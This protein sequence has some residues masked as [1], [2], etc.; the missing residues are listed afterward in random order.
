[1]QV[2]ILGAPEAAP[3][4]RRAANDG[5]RMVP[6]VGYRSSTDRF[7]RGS[8]ARQTA[9]RGRERQSALAAEP[10]LR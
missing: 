4:P 7:E 5:N 10:R 3:A 1:M 6:T 9:S 2:R 8:W